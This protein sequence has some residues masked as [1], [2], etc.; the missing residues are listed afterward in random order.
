LVYPTPGPEAGPLEQQ[1]LL[2]CGQQNISP[3]GPVIDQQ[4]VFLLG[5]EYIVNRLSSPDPFTP[6]WQMPDGEIVVSNTPLEMLLQPGYVHVDPPVVEWTEPVSG[7]TMHLCDGQILVYFKPT[8]TQLQ[9]EQFIAQFG[10]TV[11]MSWFEPPDEPGAGNS[12]AWF[13]FEYPSQMFPTFGQAY[14]FFNANPLVDFARPNTTDEFEACYC[15]D[16]GVQ[17]DWPTDQ[18]GHNPGWAC[19]TIEAYHVNNTPYVRLGPEAG[20]AGCDFS[21]QV[22]AVIDDGV[23]RSHK[24]FKTGLSENRPPDANYSYLNKISWC[25]VDCTDDAYWVGTKSKARGEPEAYCPARGGLACHGTEM[26]GMISAGTRNPSTSSGQ[27]GTGTASLAPTACILPLRIK[28]KGFSDVDGQFNT[29]TIVTAI[30]AIRFEFGHTKWIQ[31]VRV[32]NMSFAGDKGIFSWYPKGDMKYNIGR[33]LIFNDR[34]YI[35][36]AGQTYAPAH[37]QRK[38]MYPAAHDNVLGVT[39][40]LA[41]Y[42]GGGDWDFFAH[43]DSNYWDL[44]DPQENSAYPVSGIYWF[45]PAPDTQWLPVP[46]C[47]N[48][49][50]GFS[51][52]GAQYYRGGGTSEATAQISALAFLLYD[53]KARQTG[54][55]LASNRFAVKCRIVYTSYPDMVFQGNPHHVLAGVAYFRDALYQW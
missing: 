3:W 18:A 27:Y 8:T 23:L 12:I 9:I 14:A 15:D 2:D 7:Y 35:A 43:E 32:V 45:S 25:G 16:Q 4:H 5:Q 28:V 37:G 39:G 1:S 21:T 49:D 6:T 24:D 10:L 47:T 51:L 26:A 30:R 40:A 46:S 36:A 33:D 41:V 29:A 20:S 50:Y 13:Q 55:K 53:K 48:P 17:V 22:V 54:N 31:K 52:D 44:A 19:R 42:S 11:V 38:L 34:L